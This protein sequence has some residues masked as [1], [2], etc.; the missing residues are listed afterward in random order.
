[1][2]V[3][4]KGT[5]PKQCPIGTYAYVRSEKCSICPAGFKCSRAGLDAPEKCEE[6]YYNSVPGQDSCVV[7]ESGR[8]CVN[9]IN[10]LPCKAG[11]YSGEGQINCTRCPSG[12]YSK[13]LASVCLPCPAGNEC[14]D[15]S[16]PPVN[17]S[18]GFFS[19]KSDGVCKQCEAGA[20]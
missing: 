17:C 19:R 18:E 10:S 3:I 4:A 11:Y 8:E 15:P 20:Y 5:S 6:G 1:M 12:T 14:L 16:L 2:F 7:C 9:R 13:T